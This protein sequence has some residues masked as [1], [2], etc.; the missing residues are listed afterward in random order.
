MLTNGNPN[1]NL[2]KDDRYHLNDKGI[3]LQQTIKKVMLKVS[4]I[5]CIQPSVGKKSKKL[6]LVLLTMIQ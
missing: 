3:S 4:L 6:I 5:N 2:L 1:D